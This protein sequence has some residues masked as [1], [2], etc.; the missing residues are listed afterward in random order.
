MTFPGL[1]SNELLLDKVKLLF[2]ITLS[3]L[4]SFKPLRSCSSN[5]VDTLKYFLS[6]FS[7]ENLVTIRENNGLILDNINI[8]IQ[9]S[10]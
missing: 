1:W 6:P 10:H 8:K 5:N 3:K 4:V 9:R 2:V 7:D